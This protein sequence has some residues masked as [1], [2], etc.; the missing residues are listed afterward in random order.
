MVRDRRLH[1]GNVLDRRL[2]A[3]EP[4]RRGE[5]N[6]AAHEDANVRFPIVIHLLHEAEHDDG[7]R[8]AH[9]QRHVSERLSVSLTVDRGGVV[10][11]HSADRV[12][13]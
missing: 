4:K 2:N 12:F 11:G 8:R 7:H 6:C 1:P 10:H 5:N 13:A 9:D 3:H